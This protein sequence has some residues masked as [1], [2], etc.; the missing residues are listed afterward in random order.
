MKNFER[1]VQCNERILTFYIYILIF[2][3]IS[4]VLK[5]KIHQS[6]EKDQKDFNF[7]NCT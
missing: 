7:K 2:L 3:L 6:N 1:E 5:D 4:E